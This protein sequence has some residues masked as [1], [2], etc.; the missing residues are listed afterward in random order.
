[1]RP[2]IWTAML[3][4]HVTLLLLINFADLSAGM[5]VLHLFTFDPA[6]IS[7]PKLQQRLRSSGA[8]AD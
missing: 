3:G 5:I 8:S 2:W 6:W 4:L 1:M 7:A